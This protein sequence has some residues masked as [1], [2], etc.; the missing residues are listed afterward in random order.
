MSVRA[1]SWRE[2][3]TFSRVLWEIS[4]CLNANFVPH[5]GDNNTR[6]SSKTSKYWRHLLRESLIASYVPFMTDTLQRRRKKTRRIAG[7]TASTLLAAAF[8]IAG[9]APASAYV[10]TGCKWPAS[11]LTIQVNPSVTGKYSTT[12]VGAAANYRNS[13]DLKLYT[14]TTQRGSFQADVGNY[15][16]DGYEGYTNW[17]CGFGVTTNASSR[18]NTYY[19]GSAVNAR[20][21]V[22][23]LHEL[24]HAVGLNHV[25]S[26]ARVMYSSAT[27][28]YNN[29]V[30]NLTSDEVS[31]VNSLY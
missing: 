9:S 8:G 24:G 25:T 4:T 1:Y 26:T 23:W 28:A 29:G 10:T 15:G 14:S 3:V 20:I 16:A 7:L 11:S 31:G 2:A 22:V 6:L 30:R 5:L 12:L 21:Q 27:T 13:T 18:V 17:V 19:L